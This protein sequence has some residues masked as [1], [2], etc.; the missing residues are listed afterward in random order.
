MQIID[1]IDV[2]ATSISVTDPDTGEQITRP[3]RHEEDWHIDLELPTETVEYYRV[4]PDPKEISQELA[5]DIAANGIQ[6]PVRIYTNGTRGVLRDGHHR[7]AIAKSQGIT[8]MS[9]QIVA[10]LLNPYTED[11]P[12][13]EPA[14][15]GWLVQEEK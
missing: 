3:V 15:K 9:A 5:D 1:G 2:Y 7:L 8:R 14:V 4:F 13:L 12:A 6:R 10:N 11:L